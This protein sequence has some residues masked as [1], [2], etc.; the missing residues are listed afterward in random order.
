M[1]A[2]L[3]ILAADAVLREKLRM[4]LALVTKNLE[5][6]PKLKLLSKIG[7]KLMLMFGGN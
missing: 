4:R 7:R 3:R 6:G 5:R 1:I 2:N